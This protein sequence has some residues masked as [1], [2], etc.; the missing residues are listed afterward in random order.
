VVY[1]QL[2]YIQSKNIGFN[3]DQVLVIDGTGALRPNTVAFKNEIDKLSGVTSSTFSGYLPV[4]NSARSDNTFFKDAVPDVNRGLNMQVWRIDEKYIPLMGMEILAGR[5]FS[6]ERGMDSSAIILN[7]EAVRLLGFESD[8]LNQKIYGG[9][10]IEQ[11]QVEAYHVIGVVKDFNFESLRQKVGTLCFFLG[12]ADG[13][14]A[15]KVNTAYPA[16]IGQ[17]KINGDP[18]PEEPPFLPFP[19][20]V[21]YQMFKAEQQVG[22]IALA[23]SILAIS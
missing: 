21:I 8:P 16:I 11:N 19:G 20:S 15:F 5:N 13:S 1:N 18:W 17:V 14:T 22:K 10:R 2:K 3:K 7:E 4:S 23:F 12:K 9:S 6:A